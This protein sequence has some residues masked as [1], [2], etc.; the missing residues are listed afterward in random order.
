MIPDIDIWRAAILLLKRHRT[1]AAIVA[2][3][4]ADECLAGG[5]IEG[6][7]IWKAIVDAILELLR[8]A[9]DEGERVN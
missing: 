6:Q 7:Q 5:D 9:P 1:D 3:Q 4:R 2:A 8:H